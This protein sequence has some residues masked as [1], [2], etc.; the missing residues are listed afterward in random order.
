MAA[1]AARRP[2]ACAQL[3]K[4]VLAG[5]L[6]TLSARSQRRGANPQPP[7]RVSSGRRSWF[8]SSEPRSNIPRASSRFRAGKAEKGFG[9][10]F[11]SADGRAVLTVYS[12]E[13]EAGDTPASYLENNL[14]TGRSALDYER[15][16]RTLLRDLLG[17]PGAH[18]LQPL[19]FLRRRRRDPLLRPGLSAGGKARLGPVVTRISRSLRP[20]DG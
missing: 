7:V 6:A 9:Q 16:T 13:N 10:R 11:N 17:T 18:L 5:T 20:L 12:R 14:R 19:Q 15:V 3:A 2:K 8:Q 4:Y 1:A